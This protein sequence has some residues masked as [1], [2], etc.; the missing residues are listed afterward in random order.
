[1]TAFV[2]AVFSRLTSRLVSSQKNYLVS[3]TIIQLKEQKLT[4]KWNFFDYLVVLLLTSF[5]ALRFNVGAD[6][7]VYLRLFQNTFPQEN[8]WEQISAAPVDSGFTLLILITKSILNQP[9]ILFWTTSA[10]T[11]V[12]VYATLKKQSTNLPLAILLY[13]LLS[14]YVVPFNII[15]QG[16][17]MALNFWANSFLDKSKRAFFLINAIAAIFHSSVVI[18][19]LVQYLVRNWKPK[20]ITLS[21]YLVVGVVLASSLASFSSFSGF[22]PDFI[23]KYFIYFG[24]GIAVQSGI[25]TYLLI[26]AKLGLLIFALFLG[27]NSTNSRWATYIAIGVAIL[28]MSTQSVVIARMEGYF[29]IFLILLIPNQLSERKHA[30]FATLGLVCFGIAFFILYAFNYS[31]ILPYEMYP[32][33]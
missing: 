20:V 26:L 5:S 21:L 29:G 9:E 11:V 30:K 13:I 33:Y 31:S 15:R 32:W 28:I 22:L 17:A 12:P 16:I 10:L 24:E 1:M 14:F 19:A 4:K 23:S 8:W 25:G 27:I 2:L 7:P 18:V 3:N 6:Y